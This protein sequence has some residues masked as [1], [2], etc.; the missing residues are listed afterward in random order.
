[1]RETTTTARMRRD[2]VPVRITPDGSEKAMP[3]PPPQP[4]T[5]EEVEQAASADPEARP[6]TPA[7]LAAV[8]RI[9]RTRTLRRALGLTQEEFA[10]RY[11][12]LLGTL[13]DWEQ[14]RSEPDQPARA[15]L[16]GIACEPEGVARTFKNSHI[17]TIAEPPVPSPTYLLFAQAIV[18]GKQ[19]L[20]T[21]HGLPRELCPI[22]LGH[23]QG[24]EKAL[25][26]QFGG[27][28]KSGLPDWKC[29]SLAKV[30]DVQLRDGPWYAGDSHTQRQGCVEVVDLDVN[31]ASPYNPKRRLR[32]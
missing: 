17:S 7:E 27:Q 3:I 20:C 4:M 25:T 11:H 18:E 9:P 32:S 19:I 1:M 13:R 30:S 2:G 24:E 21:Y 29:L 23:S 12:I 14:G 10:A 22:I 26:Y 31:P 28:S 15:Y 8:K 5:A 6:F 16:T